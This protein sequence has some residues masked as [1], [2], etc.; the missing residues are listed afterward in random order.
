MTYEEILQRMLDRVPNSLDKREGSIIYNALAPAAAE[1][2]QLMIYRDAEQGESYADTASREGLIRRAKER[3]LAPY[4]ATKALYEVEFNMAVPIGTTFTSG[5][6]TLALK[7]LISGFKYKA[8]LEQAGAINTL[9]GNIIPVGDIPGLTL[10]QINSLLVPGED[11]EGT[12]EFRA[13]YFEDFSAQAFGGNRADYKKKVNSLSGVG[14]CKLNRV[15]TVGDNIDIVIM[16]STYGVPSVEL[17]TQVQTTIDPVVNSGQGDGLAPIGH[18]VVISGVTEQSINIVTTISYAPG[19][20]W[21]A[22][23]PYAE[24]AVDAYF[25]DLRKHW[26]DEANTIVRISQVDARLLALDGVLDV[27]GTTLNGAAQNVALGVNEVPKRGA[28]NG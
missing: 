5:T 2:V 24:A 9:T 20:N 6:Y 3:G 13:R 21:A 17:I 15:S 23:R 25:L 8:E 10:A 27:T 12:E 7:E 26:Q 11:E 19:Y 28:L 1:F 16:D 14:G 18:R 22:I 4:P